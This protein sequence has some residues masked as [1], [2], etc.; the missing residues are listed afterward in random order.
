MQIPTVVATHNVKGETVSADHVTWYAKG[1]DTSVLLVAEE[2]SFTGSYMTFDKSG[3]STNLNDASFWGF[4][5]AINVV[6]HLQ[7]QKKRTLV[8]SPRPMPRLQSSIMLMSP[9]TMALPG[10]TPTE[11]V[12]WSTSP[13]LGYTLPGPSA[14]VY[15]PLEMALSTAAISRFT[16]AVCVLPVSLAIRPEATSM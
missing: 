2:G 14:M 10:F 3:Y 15:T 11:L 9:F 4:N 7:L 16:P 1:N 6:S 8:N 13:I 5:A 12:L